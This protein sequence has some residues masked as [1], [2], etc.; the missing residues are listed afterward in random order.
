MPAL[1]ALSLSTTGCITKMILDG[2][3]AGTRQASAAI[4][5]LHD[6]EIARVTAFNGISQFE[7]MHYLAPENTD[8]LFMLTKSWTGATFGWIEDEAEQAEDDEGLE[9]PNFL[10][11]R[12]RAIAGYDRGLRYGSQLLEHY[13]PGFDS[14]KKTDKT[15]R[16]YLAQFT[17]PEEHTG[18]LFWT[19]YAWISKVNM[20]RDDPAFVGELYIGVA[21]LERVIQL[22]EKYMFGSAHTILGAYHAR[23]AMA[24]LEESKTHFEKSIAITGGKLLLAKVQY[25]A[26]YHCTKGNKDEYVKLL[27]E[28]MEAEDPFPEQRLQN[29]IAKRRAQRYLGKAR[30]R[31]CA[32]E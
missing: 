17:D 13:Y 24:E 31:E 9:G 6:Y 1:C 5:S 29:V 19:G 28:V 11:L 3:I 14:A 12:A 4:D 21:M 2:Q 25:A 23:S 27:T 16:A 15:L 30:M 7:G 26:K 8:A 20:G 22:D 32:F 18:A 10:H